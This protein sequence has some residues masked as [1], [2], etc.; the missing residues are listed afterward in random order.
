MDYKDDDF[1]CPPGYITFDYRN[2]SD[3]HVG[4]LFTYEAMVIRAGVFPAIMVFGLIAN[5]SFLFVLY[6]V[7]EMRTITNIYLANLA[8]A[9][10]LYLFMQ[11]LTT[12]LNVLTY[13]IVQ[14]Q[15]YRSSV[16]CNIGGT[17]LYMPY[18][19][20]IGL[21]TLVSF[22]RFLGICY[23]F[24]S[25][26]ISSK[27]RTIKLIILTWFLGFLPTLLRI[28]LKDLHLIFCI[29][30]PD[31]PRYNGFTHFTRICTYTNRK[32][33]QAWPFVEF[34]PFTIAMVSNS[35]FYTKII[36]TLNKRSGIEENSSKSSENNNLRNQVA[37]ML[38]ANGAAFFIC[39]SPY[40]F[41]QAVWVVMEF[42]SLPVPF[43]TPRFEYAFVRV[44]A[45]MTL[46]NS[47]IN[48]IVY[49]VSN[50]RVRSAFRQAFSCSSVGEMSTKS[51]NNSQSSSAKQVSSHQ[52]T[53]TKTGATRSDNNNN[54]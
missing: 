45:A 49:S 41:A 21:I 19:T 12:G 32:F 13:G 50:P 43:W 52:T 42:T 2:T 3:D 4:W 10:F 8:A 33:K 28:P 46:I 29:M 31:R 16:G 34:V 22:E 39:M 54:I 7:K 51:Q 26:T 48:P 6:R 25:R 11:G 9:D 53:N 23:P 36:H 1:V 15:F 35:V 40:Q 5:F 18:F 17:F 27:S 30:W 37:R 38:I 47:A 14:G 44:A 24:K 20:S